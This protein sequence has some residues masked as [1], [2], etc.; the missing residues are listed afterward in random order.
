LA[1]IESGLG[2]LPHYRAEDLEMLEELCVQEAESLGYRVPEI[3]FHLSRSEVIYDIAA[4]GLPGRY[5]HWRV[6]QQYTREKT[7]YDR[8]ESRIYE[9]V[10][11]TR[12][13]HAYLLEGNSLVAQLL[14][15]AHVIGHTSFFELSRY[16]EPA[17]KGF[18]S[19]VRASAERIDKY[20]AHYGRREVE[21]FIDDCEALAMARPFDQL[22]QTYRER[23][24]EFVAEPYDELF[25]EEREK[26]WN[27]YREE[28]DQYRKRFPRHPERDL[29][30]FIMQNSRH[31][32][33]WQR[34]II[35][36][37]REETAYFLPQRRT[38]ILNEGFAT[39][40]H[41]RILQ[42]LELCTDDFIEYQKLNARITQPHFLHYNPYNLGYLSFLELERICT[43]PEQ[44]ERE[45][46][47]WAGEIDPL[48]KMFEV[49]ASYDD[50]AFF[51][52]FLTER[53]AK[54]A[55]LFSWSVV[56]EKLTRIRVNE[57]DFES[58]SRNFVR[59]LANF[60][61]P[62]LEIVDADGRG[63][64]QLWIKHRVEHQV[65]LD[66]EYAL[67]TLPSLSRLWGRPVVVESI[68]SSTG[69]PCWYRSV[70]GGEAT[71]H[72]EEPKD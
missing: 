71:V 44:D 29:L 37:I 9:L 38:K 59:Q 40:T 25:P 17:D 61:L 53:L 55:K 47:D 43:E 45:R 68:V 49:I 63:A 70:N 54:R 18:L 72:T 2:R 1:L 7:A 30:G 27:R 33:D 57:D 46:W 15:I 39:Y 67:G 52:E 12:P 60:G 4:R 24:P 41:N 22:G 8:G 6:G 16:F 31:L 66:R 64:G 3:H 34:D 48:E 19:R 5:S 36:I 69:K 32:E 26:R 20:Y 14:V 50:Q 65:G 11:N 58:L 62:V 56:D 28:R 13:V 21:D 35:G 51:A 10:V 23:E 42:A